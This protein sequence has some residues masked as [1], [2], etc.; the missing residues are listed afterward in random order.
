M[1]QRRKVRCPGPCSELAGRPAP[2]LPGFQL[3][4]A[5]G[6]ECG[7]ELWSQSPG[8]GCQLSC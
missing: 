5:P 2:L 1:A 6:G 7:A 3:H 4:S 8:L